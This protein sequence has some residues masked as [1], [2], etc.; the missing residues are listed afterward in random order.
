[1]LSLRACSTVL[2]LVASIAAHA[3]TFGFNPFCHTL[4]AG[5]VP[6]DVVVYGQIT[7]ID[8]DG[9]DLSVIEVLRGQE[10]RSTL[11]IWDGTDFDCNGPWSMAAGDILGNVGDS[12]FIML[13]RIDTVANSWDAIGDYR[14]PSPYGWTPFVRVQGDS[15]AATFTT[16]Q[17]QAAR[18]SFEQARNFILTAQDCDALVGTSQPEAL[19]GVRV[20]TNP[21]ADRL[22][23]ELPPADDDSAYSVQL[24]TAHGQ[25]VTQLRTRE[26]R[27]ELATSALVSGT[28]TL[29][30]TKAGRRYTKQLVHR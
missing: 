28:Y 25:L 20:L 13:P 12:L 18:T 23:V 15:V 7:S 27:T 16:W 30:V 21:F 10:S 22:L 24:F 6:F 9:A 14:T 4:T 3:C 1:M 11:R 17:W 29:V 5:V 26:R 19:H 8:A 2:L